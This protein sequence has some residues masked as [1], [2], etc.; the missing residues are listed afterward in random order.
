MAVVMALTHLLQLE[1]I[2]RL[3]LYCGSKLG[4][5][6]SLLAPDTFMLWVGGVVV[7]NLTLYARDQGFDS[8]ICQS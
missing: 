5:V 7:S 8:K 2:N 1:V 6:A 4:Q 3:D